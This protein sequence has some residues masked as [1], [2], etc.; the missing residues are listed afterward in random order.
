MLTHF[1]AR[2]PNNDVFSEEASEF[3]DDVVAADELATIAM[4]PRLA[5]GG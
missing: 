4:P 3:H 2:Y 1:S 5:S